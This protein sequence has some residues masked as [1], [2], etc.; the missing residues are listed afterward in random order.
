MTER[1]KRLLAI[2]LRSCGMH[3][4]LAGEL[5]RQGDERA[6]G[7]SDILRQAHSLAHYYRHCTLVVA[8]DELIVGGGL[9]NMLPPGKSGAVGEL[10]AVPM[11]VEPHVQGSDPFMTQGLVRGAGNHTSVDYDTLLAAGFQGL[12]DHIDRRAARLSAEESPAG[13]GGMA[14][15]A[16]G[17]HGASDDKKE[18]L[19]ALK[20]FA[21]ACRD[22][23]RRYHDHALELAAKE[24]RPARKAEL[25]A[26]AA[27]C[28]AATGAGPQTFWQA[29]QC[30]WFGFYL[31]PDAPGRV[32]Q[33]L[34]PFYQRETAAGTLT[35]ERAGELIA[36][37]WMKYFQVH[38]FSTPNMARHH[39]TLGGLRGDGSDGATD[40]TDLCLE[41]F[42]ELRIPS[43]QVGVR[44]HRGMRPQT[45]RRAVAAL[46]SG[47]GSP[48]F[49]SDEQIVPAL[50]ALGVAVE[51]ARDFAMSG[52][53]EIIITGRAHMGS[54]ECFLNMPKLIRIVLGLE[55]AFAPL[56]EIKLD[57]M[58][59]IWR[60][61]TMQ[62]ERLALS[63]HDYSYARDQHAAQWVALQASLL[64]RDCIDNVKGFWQGG[65]RYNFCNCD[66]IG[67][68]NLADS[69]AVI[70]Q[71]VF[72]DR[73][74][75]LENL[76][77]ALADDWVGHETL[78]SRVLQRL[79][80]FG[81]DDARA[82]S[83][84]A[85]II[86][87]FSDLIA[88]HRPYRG[89]RYTLGTL[90]GVE[91]MHIS[92][93]TVTGATP[94]GR[95]SGQT[96]ASSLAPA[97]GRDTRGVT[98]MLNSVA[99]LPHRL[100]PTSTTVNVK[101]DPSLLRDDEGIDKIAALIEGHFRAGGQHLQ[102][103]MVN[104][105]MLLEARRNP[106]RYGD[107]MVRVAGYSAPFASLTPDIQDEI[108]ERTEHGL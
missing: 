34:W 29:C 49:C 47:T 65:A 16:A 68:A 9:L 58:D 15:R 71:L 45:L 81:N 35:R 19:D 73:A 56:P 66:I 61:L 46:R 103:S 105:A 101:L 57:S 79:P 18:Y 69:L 63:M 1:I 23:G 8:D 51:D 85:R 10:P 24:T 88:R 53:H 32:D 82:D 52:C 99:A 76:A 4:P 6:A 106:A 50:V 40:L 33:Y 78:R 60:A 95:K 22:L 17:R 30:L 91:N 59:A 70:E 102:I 83:I 21:T 2:T 96:F 48:G 28:Q 80:H 20:I 104:R 25:E 13:Q 74:V 37:L 12:I 72:I 77:A 107:V 38:G 27:N 26:I 94:D 100:L 42:E 14:T 54:V 62:M 93:G 108:L 11:T 86:T 97:P 64:T 84:A 55:P 36:C 39:L 3:D 7:L 87:T 41:V 44:W 67:A 31:L 75:T 89:G 43:P 92:F 98:A 5:A 90:A